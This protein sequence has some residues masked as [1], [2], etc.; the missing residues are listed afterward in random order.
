LFRHVPPTPSENHLSG[1]T[2]RYESGLNDSW[3]KLTRRNPLSR[4]ILTD[5]ATIP[6]MVVAI[7]SPARCHPIEKL[8]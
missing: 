2:C 6:E 8:A 1:K 5:R 7:A 4:N 3:P